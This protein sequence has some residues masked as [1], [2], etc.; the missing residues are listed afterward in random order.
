MTTKRTPIRRNVKPRI[1]AEVLALWRKI[2]EIEAE[3]D[4]R[5]WE[6]EGGR[7][8]ECMDAHNEL[9]QLL[10]IRSWQRNPAQV[11]EPEPP[12][13]MTA[14]NLLAADQWREAWKLRQAIEAAAGS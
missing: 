13:W 2:Q 5:A 1:T 3:G 10:G 7:R 9:N 4:D 12:K 11:R 8:R 14:G 6:E